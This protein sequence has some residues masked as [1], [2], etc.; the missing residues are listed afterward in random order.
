VGR[1]DRRDVYGHDLLAWASYKAGHIAEAQR[2]ATVAL[3]QALGGNAVAGALLT[4]GGTP[5]V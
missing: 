2:A 4:T 3:S 5:R 1:T